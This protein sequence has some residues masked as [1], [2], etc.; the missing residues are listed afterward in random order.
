MVKLQVT[1][2]DKVSS[3][4][5]FQRTDRL[6]SPGELETTR[7]QGVSF[8]TVTLPGYLLLVDN[9]AM[10]TGK[11]TLAVNL[12]DSATVL[13]VW[14]KKHKMR[15]STPECKRNLHF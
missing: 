15:E 8:H 11:K 10:R 5:H 12:T 6:N 3:W 13:L 2:E 1:F 7:L 9:F 4:I 14:P